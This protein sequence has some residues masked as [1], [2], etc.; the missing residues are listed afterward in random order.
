MNTPK[1]VKSISAAT[2]VAVLGMSGV[3]LAENTEKP[4]S[5]SAMDAISDSAITAK[6]KAKF[7]DDTRLKNADI[8][9]T[10]ANGA[11]TLTGSASGSEVSDAAEDLAKHVK[12]V[13]SVDNKIYTPSVAR[14]VESKTKNAAHKTERVVSDSWITTKVKSVLLADS[15]TKGFKISVKTTQHVVALSGTVDTQ[16]AID[17]AV[18]LASGIK[19]VS[20]VDSSGLTIG[21]NQ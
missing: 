19:G 16:A 1:I 9:V 14:K 10:T 2:L 17:Q 4:H 11:V 18:H 13:T 3:V 15:L 8:G 21:K 7:M 5:N 6:V 12:G 20:S